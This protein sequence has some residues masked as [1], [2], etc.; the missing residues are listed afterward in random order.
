MDQVNKVDK[1]AQMNLMEIVKYQ[2]VT[3]CYFED[4]VISDA[5]ATCFTQLC[6]AGKSDLNQFCKQMSDEGLFASPQVVRNTITLGEAKNLI[7]KE[8]G[9]KKAVCINPELNIQI[10]GNILLDFKFLCRAYA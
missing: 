10:N 3:Y 1:K 8:G 6:I 5:A 4:I 7:I 9:H 2:I